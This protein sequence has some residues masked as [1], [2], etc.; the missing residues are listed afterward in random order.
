MKILLATSAIIPAGGGIASYNQELINALKKIAVFSVLTE[1][2]LNECQGIEKVYSTYGKNCFS[3]E[4][5]CE[6]V[7]QINND[8]YD[9]II[10]SGSLLMTIMAPYVKVPICS[11]SHFVDGM[12]ALKAGFNSKYISK[13]IALS[14]Y[15]KKHLK[16]RFNIQDEGCVKVVYNFVHM[17]T[18]R[19]NE[20]KI[21]KQP[22][23]IVYPGGTSI[24]KSFDV[25]MK[26]LRK[27]IRTNLDFKFFWLGGTTLPSAKICLASTCDK[28]IKE[29][30]R[31]VFTGRIPRNEAVSI[32]QTANVFLLPSRG[33]G[34]PM[35]LLE[36]MQEGCI[37]VVSDAKHGSRELLEDGNFGVIVKNE[38]IESLYLALRDI[39]EHPDKYTSNYHKT[40]DY[41]R[42]KLSEDKWSNTMNS[43]IQECIATKKN[44]EVLSE[45]HFKDNVQQLKKEIKKERAKTMLSSLNTSLQCSWLYLTK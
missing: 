38:K 37:P 44:R 8:N 16:E 11:I 17:N 41:V 21:N 43:I 28:L 9:I 13:I 22:L 19:F 3:Y 10:N 4:Y 1:E 18:M 14:Y 36:A 26:V 23:M 40:F 25:V 7:D 15:G 2:N 29:D 5:C 45:L 6:M 30:S 31:V 27:L 42:E 12:L 34:C 33:E 39:I 35:T 24:K 32:I 20:H